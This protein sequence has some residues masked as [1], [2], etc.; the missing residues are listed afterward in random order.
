MARNADGTNVRELRNQAI[1]R[2]DEP[3]PG[4][5]F[6]DEAADITE[7]QA[8]A[9]LARLNGRNNA[10]AAWDVEPDPAGAAVRFRNFVPAEPVAQAGRIFAAEYGANPRY[11]T[12]TTTTRK[13][14][15]AE[16]ETI[17]LKKQSMK[18]KIP[19]GI[20][21]KAVREVETRCP[22]H[23]LEDALMRL[24]RCHAAIKII[25]KLELIPKEQECMV[26]EMHYRRPYFFEEFGAFWEFT[27][28]LKP[29]RTA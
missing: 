14:T 18:V 6:V 29:Y 28:R 2:G 13:R 12:P 1:G 7:E 16:V 27:L 9:A 26:R 4:Q 15:K 8:D 22:S 25:K 21:N 23:Q 17:Y 11:T 5:F 19:S 20:L 10:R 3:L 24:E